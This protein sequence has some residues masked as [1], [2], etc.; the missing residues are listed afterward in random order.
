MENFGLGY[1]SFRALGQSKNVLKTCIVVITDVFEM[2]LRHVHNFRQSDSD[3]LKTCPNLFMNISNID[4]KD[5][6]KN[7]FSAH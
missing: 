6:P 2:P 4:V 7:D 5:I 3:V 1:D